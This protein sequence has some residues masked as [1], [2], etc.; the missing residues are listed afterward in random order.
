MMVGKQTVDGD[1]V[2]AVMNRL[3][4]SKCGLRR[5]DRSSTLGPAWFEL[6]MDSLLLASPIAF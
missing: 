4:S 6:R 3:V 5:L 2:D 1:S